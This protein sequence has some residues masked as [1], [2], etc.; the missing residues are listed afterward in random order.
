M[1]FSPDAV[2]VAVPAAGSADIAASCGVVAEAA[3]T[4]VVDVAVTAWGPVAA[5]GVMDIGVICGVVAAAAATGGVDFPATC[6]VVAA[7]AATGVVDIAAVCGAA[8]AVAATGFVDVVAFAPVSFSRTRCPSGVKAV[9]SLPP[10]TPLTV[11]K[12]LRES[13]TTGAPPG[14]HEHPHRTKLTNEICNATASRELRI[15]TSGFMGS[16]GR[17]ARFPIWHSTAILRLGSNRL[18][19]VRVWHKHSAL[20]PRSAAQ[21]G[22][23][24]GSRR[25]V[26]TAAVPQP[27]ERNRPQCLLMAA[28][29]EG[30]VTDRSLRN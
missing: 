17:A 12:G 15:L 11:S 23:H 7:V 25:I 26:G 19:S 20:R 27:F 13:P 3:V 28:T 5:A 29:E 18:L 21:S 24:N 14:V 10:A 22:G 9:N 1:R 8:A 16:C 6:A 4:G 30:E 2:P